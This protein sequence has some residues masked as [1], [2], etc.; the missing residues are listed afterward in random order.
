MRESTYALR[1]QRQPI[2]LFLRN[3]ENATSGL[4]ADQDRGGGLTWPRG[5]PT[6]SPSLRGAA[7]PGTPP[8]S[9][10]QTSWGDVDADAERRGE[11]RGEPGGQEADAL[12]TS[13]WPWRPWRNPG[14][15]RRGAAGSCLR[16]PGPRRSP[17]SARPACASQSVVNVHPGKNEMETDAEA[18]K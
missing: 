3:P 11:A 18:R 6:C 8:C 15:P 12:L 1:R 10:D 5:T 13:T 4:W 16:R 9:G 2:R 17:S 7:R 14:G